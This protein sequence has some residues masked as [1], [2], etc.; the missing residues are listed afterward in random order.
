MGSDDNDSL[1]YWER[2][3]SP[4]ELKALKWMMLDP[5]RAFCSGDLTELPEI[6]SEGTGRN[7]I[8]KFKKLDLIE[9]YCKS[10]YAFYKLKS[11]DK[12]KIK[13]PMTLHRMGDKGLKR[14]QVDFVALLDSLSTE[15]LCKVHNVH[16]DFA[17]EGLY[18]I[19]LRN[20][21]YKFNPISKDI[22]FGSFVWSKYR[23]LKITLHRN[24]TVSSVLDC[25]NFPVEASVPGFVSM[26]AFLGGIRNN[27]H[28]VCKTIQ[29]ELTED[30]LPLVENWLVTQWHYGKDSAQ[31]FSGESFNITFKMWCGE[32]ARI[33]VHKQDQTRK[34]RLEVIETPKKPLQQ[35]IAE[36][37]NLCC[38]KCSESLKHLAVSTNHLIVAFCYSLATAISSFKTTKEAS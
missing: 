35:L 17:A 31:E 28:N 6:N 23:S 14:I 15:E 12:T 7:I 16:L 30:R 27:L 34:V 20:E 19:L 38:G 3:L 2:L 29:P 4:A 11:A 5:T 36:K 8:W 24:G 37:L 10:I 1:E 25:S 26:A 33:Y 22:F 13:K 32:L 9:L 18:D 21:A